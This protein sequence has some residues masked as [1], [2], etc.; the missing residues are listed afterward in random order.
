M[1]MYGVCFTCIRIRSLVG[2][3]FPEDEPSGSKHIKDSK[4]LKITILIW[5]SC[6]LSVYVT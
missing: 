6:I 1:H 2:N 3:R 5:K 4:T